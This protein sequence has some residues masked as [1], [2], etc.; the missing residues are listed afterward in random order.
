MIKKHKNY[1]HFRYSKIE[2][3]AKAIKKELNIKNE[4]IITFE[5]SGK[6]SFAAII[7]IFDDNIVKKD[8]VIIPIAFQTQYL[9]DVNE[10]L[11]ENVKNLNKIYKKIK[12]LVV[13]DID[14]LENK[15]YEK[16]TNGS[17]K[18]AKS[19]CPG[20]H[21]VMHYIFAKIT[22]KLGGHQCVGGEREKH[23]DKLKLNQLG[24]ALDQYE[25]FVKDRFG[26]NIIF[27]LRKIKS[28]K[29]VYEI[30]EKNFPEYNEVQQEC[31]YK[32]GERMPEEGT[33]EANKLLK[34]LF[35]SETITESL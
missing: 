34:K 23:N 2:E 15:A 21:F 8:S 31:E 16:I 11:G 25:Q 12:P 13:V 35:S 28:D 18:I 24:Y 7:K 14:F 32:K 17:I 27:P 4:H 33:K 22:K 3:L 9:S 30:I 1:I 10:K 5:T 20:C 19:P 26:I 6:D 29:K